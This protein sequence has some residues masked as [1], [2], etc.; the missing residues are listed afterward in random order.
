MKRQGK[1]VKVISEQAESGVA[2]LTMVFSTF[3]VDSVEKIAP[4]TVRIELSRKV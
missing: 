3:K 2:I 1:E 4:N